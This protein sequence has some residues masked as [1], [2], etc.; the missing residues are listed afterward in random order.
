MLLSCAE[1]FVL[2]QGAA[3]ASFPGSNGKISFEST[4]TGSSQIISMSPNGASQTN[5]TRNR[6]LDHAVSP[7][8]L[9]IA[10][11]YARVAWMIDADGTGKWRFVANA[12]DASPSWYLTARRSPS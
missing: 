12:G 1:A 8:G 11:E 2:V 4:R 7:G 10:Y 9:R 5:V 3:D 6:S